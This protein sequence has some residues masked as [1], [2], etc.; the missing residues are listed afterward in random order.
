MARR[1]DISDKLIHFTSGG[2]CVNDA[3]TRLRVIT[4]EG[5]LIG[6]RMIRGGYRC[7]SFTEA[8]LPAFA[9]AFNS[10]F[11]FTRYSQF[12]L[13]FDKNWIFRRGADL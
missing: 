7:V 1:F 6:S 10:E 9:P 8:L 13:M 5:R 12:G 3:F 2:E 11:P 4:R